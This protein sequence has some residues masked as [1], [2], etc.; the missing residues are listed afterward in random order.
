MIAQIMRI[1]DSF[2]NNKKQLPTKPMRN[3][4]FLLNERLVHLMK[5]ANTLI[6]YLK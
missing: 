1:T 5:S 3:A 2:G 4:G 6:W